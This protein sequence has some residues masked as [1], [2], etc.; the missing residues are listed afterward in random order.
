MYFN[1]ILAQSNDI[2]KAKAKLCKSTD[3]LKLLTG[4]GVKYWDKVKPKHFSY[5]DNDS[6]GWRF[7]KNHSLFEYYYDSSYRH[8]RFECTYGRD[9]IIGETTFAVKSDTII[10]PCEKEKYLITHLSNDT[11]IVRRILS[12]DSISQEAIFIKSKDQRTTVIPVLSNITKP[13]KQVKKSIPKQ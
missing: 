9:V 10:L 2:L 4:S 12:K 13:K 7:K 6:I 5:C 8:K 1:N 11:L 3:T